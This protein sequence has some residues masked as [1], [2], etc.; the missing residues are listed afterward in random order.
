[1]AI[2]LINNTLTPHFEKLMK[3]NKEL[4]KCLDNE[5]GQSRM[6]E[7]KYKELMKENEYLQE[8]YNN[9][10]HTDW[11]ADAAGED[12]EYFKN[13]C[14]AHTLGAAIKENKELKEKYEIAWKQSEK[15]VAAALEASL[16]IQELKEKLSI[17]EADEE[18]EANLSCNLL[19][20]NKKLKEEIE[21][22]KDKSVPLERLEEEEE[23][24]EELQE[25]ITCLESDS[26]NEVSQAEFDDMK[27]GL[28]SQIKHLASQVEQGSSRRQNAQLDA[29]RITE[30]I[31]K[32]NKLYHENKALK[33]DGDVLV[34]KLRNGLI[35]KLKEENID[36]KMKLVSAH[37]N[38]D[39]QKHNEIAGVIIEENDKLKE[40]NEKLNKAWHDCWGGSL[41]GYDTFE[42]AI[43][44]E[45]GDE[46]EQAKK[47]GF[48]VFKHQ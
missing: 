29:N 48:G 22:L 12:R 37:E 1:M 40:E 47:Y 17:A 5:A 6:Y 45:F 34:G 18:E 26:H 4:K 20:E 41:C 30:L 8:H 46:S 10:I 27:E 14:C 19:E 32:N 39:V 28:E 44:G 24:V 3:E 7:K 31:T 13:V 38:A 35:E 2:N 15:S 23:K 33:E 43:V 11:I 21:E 25:K 16:E 42:E 36:L 9:S